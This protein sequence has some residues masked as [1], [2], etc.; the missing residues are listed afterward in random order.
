MDVVAQ[1]SFDFKVGRSLSGRNLDKISQAVSLLNDVLST[2]PAQGKSHAELT[3]RPE[4]IF[5]VKQLIDPVA[6]YYGTSVDIDVDS[7]TRIDIEF[8]SED[9]ISAIKTALSAVGLE[10]NLSTSALH[11]AVNDGE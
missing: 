1:K 11:S 10:G 5:E 7:G 4:E 2:N 9:E 8:S 6:E 3:L